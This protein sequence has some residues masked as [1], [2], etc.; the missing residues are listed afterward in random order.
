VFGLTDGLMNDLTPFENVLAMKIDEPLSLTLT[1][2][3]GL[4][5][6]KKWISPHHLLLF[7]I[8]ES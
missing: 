2:D 6:I 8:S 3:Q 7:P 5:N 1:G 4:M